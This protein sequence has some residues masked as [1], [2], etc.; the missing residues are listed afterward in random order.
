MTSPLAHTQNYK[1]SYH[2]QVKAIQWIKTRGAATGEKSK[3]WG[4]WQ[5]VELLGVWFVRGSQLPT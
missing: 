2:W 5:A 3:A 1:K 4:L